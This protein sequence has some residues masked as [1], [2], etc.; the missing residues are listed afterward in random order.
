MITALLIIHGLSAVALL[1]ALTH[2]AL[3][4]WWPA[5]KRTA[6]FF[7]NVRAVSSTS[8]T[9]AIIVLFVITV[10]LGS[11]IY[12]AYRV[13]IRIV[14]QDYRMLVPEGSFELKEH[15]VTIGLGLLP[16]YWFFWQ[17]PL[18]PETAGTRAA[19]TTILAFIV[20]WAFLVGHVLNNIRGFGS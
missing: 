14:L 18:Q 4:V 20:W 11:V 9:N 16:A 17:R 12:P 10:S 6:S 1:G 15:F 5:P 7:N 8:Y 13:G 2:Q 19:L 3:S